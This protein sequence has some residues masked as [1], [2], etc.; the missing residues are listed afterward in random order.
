MSGVRASGALARE[1]E[2]TSARG[3]A[4]EETL[5]GPQSKVGPTVH[6]TNFLYYGSGGKRQ[7]PG[8]CSFCLG[9]CSVFES[10]V[11]QLNVIYMY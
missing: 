8:S 9:S 11:S 6:V 5:T 4:H 10:T 3:G 7:V 2:G 1:R